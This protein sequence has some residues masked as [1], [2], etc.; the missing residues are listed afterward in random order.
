MQHNSISPGI[1]SIM[2]RYRYR[3]PLIDDKAGI[4]RSFFDI[5]IWLLPCN[6]IDFSSLSFYESHLR[7]KYKLLNADNL[8]M[9]Y[10]NVS[11]LDIMHG[12][13]LHDRYFI[14]AEIESR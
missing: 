14:V 7:P 11:R 13:S 5:Q 6:S 9:V 4:H 3:S 10:W 12:L 1:I 2:H 8:G